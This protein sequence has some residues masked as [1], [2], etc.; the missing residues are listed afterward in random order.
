MEGE[1]YILILNR[2]SLTFGYNRS[3]I[4][5]GLMPQHVLCIPIAFVLYRCG[6]DV[7]GNSQ[8]HSTVADESDERWRPTTRTCP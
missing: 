5:A 6:I 4:F 7:V 1:N 8:A 3:R 2:R